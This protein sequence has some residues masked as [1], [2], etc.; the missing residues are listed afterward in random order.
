[1]V[2]NQDRVALSMTL[3]VAPDITL[4]GVIPLPFRCGEG[5]ETTPDRA[6]EALF[7]WPRCW[8]GFVGL[9]QSL[10]HALPL[11]RT[12]RRTAATN[13]GN[14]LK[15]R[16]P[17]LTARARDCHLWLSAMRQSLPAWLF[18]QHVDRVGALVK[19][20][21]KDADQ[22]STK[23]IDTVYVHAHGNG[24]GVR[25]EFGRDEEGYELTPAVRRRRA[26]AWDPEMRP[27]L[28]AFEIQGS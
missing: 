26:L 21:Y 7:A 3:A 17:D 1:M 19:K 18:V 2:R 25:L 12:H 15:I 23:H 9:V 4:W 22:P 20:F 16:N 13:T 27:P 28:P 10:V 14:Q 11:C 6:R 5:R 8:A 24:V